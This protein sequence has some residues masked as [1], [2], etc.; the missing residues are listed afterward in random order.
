MKKVLFVRRS[1]SL[2]LETNT[3]CN[4]TWAKS[5]TWTNR[6]FSLYRSK[7]F[8]V[9]QFLRFYDQR[10]GRT[11][12]LHLKKKKKNKKNDWRKLNPDYDSKYDNLIGIFLF[13][14]SLWFLLIGVSP[15]SRIQ[16]AISFIRKNVS[17]KGTFCKKEYE[18]ETRN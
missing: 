10:D 8:S 16:N 3:V 11:D 15:F 12:R 9:D 6:V 18:F 1:M 7:L 14:F 5:H 2:K 13:D 4:L 17:E